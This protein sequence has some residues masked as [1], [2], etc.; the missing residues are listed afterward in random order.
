MYLSE[1]LFNLSTYIY[2][3]TIMDKIKCSIIWIY[4]VTEKI[5]MFFLIIRTTAVTVS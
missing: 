2:V 1:N 4:I 5:I 3:A